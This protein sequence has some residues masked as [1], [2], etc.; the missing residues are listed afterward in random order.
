MR[1]DSPPAAL[2]LTIPRSL[3]TGQYLLHGMWNANLGRVMDIT[4][5]ETQSDLQV[6]PDL[7]NHCCSQPLTSD[8]EI[9]KIGNTASWA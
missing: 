9:Q 2:I 4:R 1:I 5:G 6:S 8:A 7:V 3:Q